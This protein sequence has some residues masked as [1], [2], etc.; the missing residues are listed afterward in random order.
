LRAA[1]LLLRSLLTDADFLPTR[2]RERF[3]TFFSALRT[4]ALLKVP[5]RLRVRETLARLARRRATERTD[6]RFAYARF[7]REDFFAAFFFAVFF[8]LGLATIC[9]LLDEVMHER[10]ASTAIPQTL[11][12]RAI[13]LITCK[14]Y[15]RHPL[16]EGFANHFTKILE[17][18]V[19]ATCANARASLA[20][21]ATTRTRA[22]IRDAHNDSRARSRFRTR[23]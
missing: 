13:G 4:A 14:M 10:I 20:R 6:A 17:R 9:V 7:L 21:D 2:L 15:L 8:F 1:P 23:G 12:C 3:E 16:C 11:P 22:R 18:V 19:R 5:F